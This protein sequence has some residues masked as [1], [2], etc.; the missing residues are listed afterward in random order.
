MTQPINTAPEPS[1]ST[2]GWTYRRVDEVCDLGRGRVISQED[3][4][5][6]SG[7]YLVFSSQ[8]KDDGVFGHLDSYDF[9][10]D[11]VTWTAD[12]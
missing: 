4:Q 7:I 3:I 6:H 9:E 2:S 5:R 1:G 10:G 12:R 8:S 11:Y